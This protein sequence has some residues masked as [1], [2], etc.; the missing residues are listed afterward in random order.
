MMQWLFLSRAEGWKE[1]GTARD[2]ILAVS[3]NTPTVP[4]STILSQYR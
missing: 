2:W 3:Q 4:E 1:K